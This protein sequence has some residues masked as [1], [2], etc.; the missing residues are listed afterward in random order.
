M[1]ASP[2]LPY[3]GLRSFKRDEIH[4]FFGRDR[5]TEVLIERL[6]RSR[7]LAVL[8]SSGTGKSSLVKTGLLSAL[9]MGLLKGGGSIWRVVDF[10]PGKPT[11]SPI[12]NLAQRL[13]ETSGEQST[14]QDVDA[15]QERLRTEGPR[16]LLRWCSEGHLPSDTNLLLLVDQFEEL[17]RR[18]DRAGREEAEAFVSLLLESKHP[19]EFSDPRMAA[20]PVFLTLTMRSEYLGAC[21]LIPGLAEAINE[22]VYLTPRMTR[23]ECREAIIGP[24]RVCGF[25]LDDYLANRILNDL[26]NFMPWETD[27]N[28]GRSISTSAQDQLGRVARRA[29]QLPIMQHALNQIWQKARDDNGD[30]VSIAVRPLT[31]A[32]YEA[33]GGIGGALDQHANRIFDALPEAHKPL[34]EA[35]FRALTW[36][37]TVASAVRQPTSFENLVRICGGDEKAVR[38]VVDVFRA[39]T[40]NFLQPETATAIE[41]NTVIDITHESLIRQWSKLGQWV[42]AEAR[43]AETYRVIESRAR[44]WKENKDD[45]L[46]ASSLANATSWRNQQKTNDA[47]AARYGNSFDLALE[48]LTESEEQERRRSEAKR[49][50]ELRSR[51]RL[52]VFAAVSFILLII[53]V[54]RPTLLA[55]LKYGVN[56]VLLKIAGSIAPATD[57]PKSVSVSSNDILSSIVLASN[58]SPLDIPEAP[59]NSRTFAN[60]L[61]PIDLQTLNLLIRQGYPRE[62]LLW[63]YLDTFQITLPGSQTFSYRYN[64]PD[65]Y[66]CSQTD[67]KH[68][69]YIDWIRASVLTGLTVE[70]KTSISLSSKPITYARLCFDASLAQQAA[71]LVSP[72]TVEASMANLDVQAT[73]FYNSPLTCGSDAWDPVADSNTAQPNVLSLF[74]GGFSLTFV[75]RTG[76]GLFGFL[77]TLLKVKRAQTTPSKFAFIPPDRKYAADAPT[78]IT[79]SD[80]PELLTINSGNTVPTDSCFATTEVGNVD[81]CVPVEAATTKRIFGIL[82]E[83]IGLNTQAGSLPDTVTVPIPAPTAPAPSTPPK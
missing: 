77:G 21:S 40:C 82:S 83:L 64:P 57:A 79:V 51:R 72:A 27:G 80:D 69:C 1:K 61:R 20:L 37:T 25:D 81:Y 52:V 54:A 58:N 7:F 22:S 46:T 73:V 8:G 30:S 48:Y 38:S 11:W 71:A 41:D 60:L 6:A 5:C 55:E 14:A 34:V 43:A 65:D 16:A 35:I 17:F 31:L 59:E 36:G 15:L 78:L 68:R 49:I 28:S 32:D 26:A 63:L 23:E 42:V 24:A 76:A 70:E 53:G 67:P 33:I 12:R 50:R 9:E 29:D 4:L 66:G 2:S 19:V 62:L 45:L 10:Q 56:R 75:P 74:A 39:P 13:I 18:D 47:W 3:P 44:L